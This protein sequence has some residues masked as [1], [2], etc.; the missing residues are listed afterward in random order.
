MLVDLVTPPQSHCLEF[1]D[2]HASRKPGEPI[3]GDSRTSLGLGSTGTISA[4]VAGPPPPRKREGGTGKAKPGKRCSENEA[5]LSKADTDTQAQE[6]ERLPI[7]PNPA[8]VRSAHRGDKE[9]MDVRM[10]GIDTYTEVDIGHFKKQQEC[11]IVRTKAKTEG[12]DA[13]DSGDK[14]SL[15]ALRPHALPP[16]EENGGVALRCPWTLVCTTSLPYPPSQPSG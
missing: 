14:R 9:E 8:T 6:Q 1:R 12:K 13:C 7:R 16:K 3:S 5:G 15:P 10:C 2:D 11:Q 4:S